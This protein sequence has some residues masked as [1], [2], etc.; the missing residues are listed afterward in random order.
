MKIQA[1]VV[2]EPG[3]EIVLEEVQLDEPK[4]NEVLIKMVGTGVCHTDLGVQASMS[5]RPCRSRWGMKGRVRR[6]SRSGR[7]GI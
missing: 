1:A 2:H 5:R 3:G 6:K 7:H 4:A